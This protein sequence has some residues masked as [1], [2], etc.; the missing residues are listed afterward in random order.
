M[1]QKNKTQSKVRTPKAAAPS[2]AKKGDG[3]VDESGQDK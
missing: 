2:T 3:Q 1:A